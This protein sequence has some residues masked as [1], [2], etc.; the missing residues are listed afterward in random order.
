[1]Q[2]PEAPTTL[3]RARQTDVALPC[4]PCAMIAMQQKPMQM[5]MTQGSGSTCIDQ[6]HASKFSHL[7]LRTWRS[8][9]SRSQVLCSETISVSCLV[10]SPRISPWKLLETGSGP[11][12]MTYAERVLKLDSLRVR[13]TKRCALWTAASTAAWPTC[14]WERLAC[15]ISAWKLSSSVCTAA[16][17][18]ASW[19]DFRLVNVFETLS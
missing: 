7:Y 14:R 2:V 17:A 5:I 1:M 18:F 8:Q 19:T 4:A 16:T 11:C 12:P 6:M 10:A 13:S 15:C 9:F 3:R